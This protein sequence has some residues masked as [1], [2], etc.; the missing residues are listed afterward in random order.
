MHKR[1]KKTILSNFLLLGQKMGKRSQFSL[2]F[3]GK[4]II[5]TGLFQF[6]PFYL[7]IYCIYDDYK[8][9]F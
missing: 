7:Y 3:F 2:T 1:L 5:H 6:Q 4:S 9:I 8:Y